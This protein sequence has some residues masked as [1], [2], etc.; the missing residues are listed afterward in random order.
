MIAEH[1]MVVLTNDIP[2]SGLFAGDV[3]AVVHVYPGGSAYEVEF[4]DGDGST[5]ACIT[6]DAKNVRTIDVRTIDRGELLHTRR[7]AAGTNNSRDQSPRSVD[8]WPIPSDLVI[9]SVPRLK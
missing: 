8:D 6:L 9:V 2:T 4:V 3:G 5:V 7:H 1:S